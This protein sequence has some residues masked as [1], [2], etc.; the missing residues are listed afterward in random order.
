MNRPVAPALEAL[1]AVRPETVLQGES[2]PEASSS[3]GP[4]THVVLNEQH[5]RRV[6]ALLILA[7]LVMSCLFS[8]HGI[9]GSA[10]KAEPSPIVS[11]SKTLVS[12]VSGR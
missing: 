7:G 6:P 1:A 5:G 11:A 3:Q 2:S 9:Y 4:Q 12:F 8:L 10:P